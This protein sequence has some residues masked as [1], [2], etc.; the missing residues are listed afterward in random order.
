MLS[1]QLKALDI[2]QRVEHSP[3]RLSDAFIDILC[4]IALL[5]KGLQQYRHVVCLRTHPHT[6]KG[7][8]EASGKGIHGHNDLTWYK[9]V[10]IALQQGRT[11]VGGNRCDSSA[12]CLL[13]PQSASRP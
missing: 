10:L 9:Y 5:H 2:E 4:S 11:A 3:L 8:V 12:R 1:T 6:T 7:Q 13:L